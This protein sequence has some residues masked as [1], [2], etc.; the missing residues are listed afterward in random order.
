VNVADVRL[1]TTVRVAD[2]RIGA[3]SAIL[4]DETGD[5]AF[6]LE[7]SRRSG[8]RWFVPWV[9]LDLCGDV[10]EASSPLVFGGPEQ[11]D[12]YARRGARFV[13]DDDARAPRADTPK[14]TR[15]AGN[16]V[17]AGVPEGTTVS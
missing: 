3:V 1:G 11:L 6:G 10:V 9:A 14:P 4:V 2:V 7:V 13:R 8:E 15:R 12:A 17:S 5:R 16:R